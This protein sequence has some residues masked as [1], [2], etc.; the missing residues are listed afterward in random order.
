MSSVFAFVLLLLFPFISPKSPTKHTI[1][2][3]LAAKVAKNLVVCAFVAINESLAL[4]QTYD[5]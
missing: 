4:W 5:N 3:D 1:K 2:L